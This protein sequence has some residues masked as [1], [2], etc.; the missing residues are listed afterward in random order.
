M[1]ELT[2][3]NR[4]V[5]IVNVMVLT[6]G[7]VV[8]SMLTECVARVLTGCGESVGVDRICCYECIDRVCCEGVRIDRVCVMSVLIRCVVVS[9]VRGFANNYSITTSNNA[10]VQHHLNLTWNGKFKFQGTSLQLIII[11]RFRMNGD[12]MCHVAVIIYEFF[13]FIMDDIGDDLVDSGLIKEE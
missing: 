11:L 7:V 1:V 5:V 10:A 8:M 4:S 3:S 2:P 6:R 12:E 13:F 9:I